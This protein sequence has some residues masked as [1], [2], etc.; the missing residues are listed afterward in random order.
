MVH[1][2]ND[3]IDAA[4]PPAMITLRSQNLS[5]SGRLV[6]RITTP[7]SAVILIIRLRGANDAHLSNTTCGAQFAWD[8]AEI[9]FFL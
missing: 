3:G 6:S 7:L 4:E 8:L 5:N 2:L 1:G 9:D